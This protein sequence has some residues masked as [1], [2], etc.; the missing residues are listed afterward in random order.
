M[1]DELREQFPWWTS[2]L[3]AMNIPVVKVPGWEG[4]D[5][6]GTISAR[7]RRGARHAHCLLVSGDKDVNQLAPTIT[8][9]R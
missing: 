8:H 4:D 9:D 5:I 3:A 2:L 7:S 1:D 6:L